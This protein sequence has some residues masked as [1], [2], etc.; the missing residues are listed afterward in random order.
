MLLLVESRQDLE[1]L[2][3]EV[4][5]LLRLL[6]FR[7]N[8]EKSN[9]LPSHKLVYLGLEIPHDT[10]HTGGESAEDPARLP[11]GTPEGQFHSTGALE[12]DWNDVATTLAVLPAPL[13]YRELQR[14][15]IDQLKATQS[16]ET[17][18]PLNNK[19]KEELQW[20]S[21]MLN[22]WNGH[23]ILPLTPDLVIETD[24]SLLGWGAATQKLSTGGLWSEEERSHH[25]NHL[26]LA[27]AVKTFTKGQ[28]NIHVHLKMDNTA[29]IAYIN[30]MGAQGHKHCPE[31]PL[32]CGAFPDDRRLC[33]VECLKE[34]EQRTQR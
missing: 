3:Q 25:M 14:L 11:N 15:K 33:V 34:Y 12:I 26:E 4:L 18:I 6:G 32:S 2:S 23:P 16:F 21:K 27:L 31:Q 24:A 29:S 5:S 20:W 13:H 22:S 9:L 30:R 8:W 7:I 1:Q 17:R 28:E 10:D 19:A